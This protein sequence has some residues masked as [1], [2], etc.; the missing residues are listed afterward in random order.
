MLRF[1]SGKLLE[2]ALV[3]LAVSILTFALVHWTG[4]LAVAMGGVEASAQDIERLRVLHGLDRP[5]WVQYA[6]WVQRVLQGDFGTSFFSKE[7]VFSLILARLPVTVALA[8]L[9]LGLGLLIG[10]PL[11]VLAAIR[12]GSWLDRFAL[13][14]AVLGQA[15]PAYWSALLLILL[16][17]VHW[18]VLPISGTDSWQNFVLPA[19]A[20]AWFVMPVLMR[21]TRAGMIDVLAAD[22]VRTARAKGLPPRVVLFKHALRNA[23]MPVVA[24]AAVQLG[25]M[26]GG[27]IVIESVFSLNG[28]GLL[29]W[30]AIQ[31]SD[32]PVVQAIVMIVAIV[33]V[34]LN[35]LSDLINALLDPRIRAA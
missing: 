11:G 15:M 5:A 21:L 22:Y 33:F 29:A 27:S 17:G 30:N 8:F 20:L 32:F 9:S 12:P 28:V 3:C 25:F 2:A 26:L 19:V 1:L 16:F 31:R 7:D 24:I 4:D 18:Q 35:L 6:D 23:L 34:M 13:S 14:L 10:V